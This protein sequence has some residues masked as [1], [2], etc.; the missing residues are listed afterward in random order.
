M[1]QDLEDQLVQLEKLVQMARGGLLVH[2]DLQAKRV[3][4]EDQDL[5]VHEV[6]LA[7]LERQVPWDQVDS[8]A[9]KEELVFLGHLVH[10]DH[11]E[12]TDFR[13][14][15]V[16]LGRLVRQAH[17]VNPDL[18]VCLEILDV[19]DHLDQLVQ[20]GSGDLQGHLGL[21]VL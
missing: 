16:L 4:W 2:Q 13:V 20:V 19:S 10:R 8:P 6:I 9:R 12:T 17:W 7:M 1:H 21:Q 3:H 18:E 14:S 15:E 5:Q 11:V